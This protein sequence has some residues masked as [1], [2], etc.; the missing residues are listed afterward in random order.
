MK[1][2]AFY[3]EK[4]QEWSVI[5]MSENWEEK[6]TNGGKNWNF[7]HISKNDVTQFSSSQS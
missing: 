7:P 3:L 4:N 2:F 1:Y 5:K 6:H